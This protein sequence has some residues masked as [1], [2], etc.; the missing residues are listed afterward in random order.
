[1]AV[2]DSVV[3][4]WE[5]GGITAQLMALS[6]QSEWQK[7][8]NLTDKG[9]F[10]SINYYDLLPCYPGFIFHSSTFEIGFPII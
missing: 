3:T 9:I 6:S 7:L 10:I 8:R 4:R 5:D 2:V 1:M